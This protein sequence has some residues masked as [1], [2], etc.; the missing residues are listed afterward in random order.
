MFT[1]LIEDVGQLR[2]RE[3]AG[4][5]GRLEVGTALPLAEINPGDSIAV[6]GVCLTV[7]RCGGGTLAFH[8]LE[9][10]LSLTNLGS[11][12]VGGSLNLE[13]ALRAGDRLGG[14]FVLGH[15]DATASVLRIGRDGDDLVVEMDIPEGLEPLLIP[16]GS[17]AVDGIS[18]TIAELKPRSFAV[19]VIP[20]TWN[21]T[22][23]RHAK[24][25]A[26]VNLEADML[27]KY[28]LRALGSLRGGG[29]VSMDRLQQ[30]GF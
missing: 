20:H 29:N 27:G 17:I 24:P 12:P 22:A 2:R 28:A 8:T 14:H 26:K 16:R 13:R 21:H 30:A 4:K 7:E 19:H 25:G 1:G 5:A 3:T 10:T 18:L 9:Q 11:I 23:L 6:N 15:V